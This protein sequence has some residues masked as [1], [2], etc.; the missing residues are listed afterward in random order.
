[1]PFK[2][3]VPFDGNISGGAG[4]ATLDVLTNIGGKVVNRII[5]TLGGGALTKAMLT[6]VKM[7]ASD[8]DKGGKL[9]F[10]ST[11]ARTDSR[12][13]YRGIAAAAAFL[14]IDL[15]EIRS[16]TVKGQKLGSYDTR[17]LRTLQLEV[18]V[19]GATAPT[20]VAHA[21]FDEAE[22]YDKLYEPAER[23]LMAKVLSQEYAFS[24]AGTFPIKIPYGLVGGSLIKRIFYHGA[25]VTAAEVRKDGLVIFQAADALNDYVQGEFSRTS[26]ANIF[27]VDFIVDGNQ[28][29]AL[30]AAMAKSMEFYVTVSGAGSVALEMELLDPL[31]NN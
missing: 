23:A 22:D 14:T 1:M 6:S 17:L 13:Q 18:V 12:Q 24:A 29:Y 5:L 7:R 19:A 3:L 26:Q 20:L 8:T 31:G 15:N 27:C 16:K 21:A 4:T 28:S 11:G 25:I 9:V 30:N 10:D 2:Q